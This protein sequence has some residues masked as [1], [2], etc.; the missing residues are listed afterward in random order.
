MRGHV[1]VRLA[2]DLLRMRYHLRTLMIVLALGPMVLA[3]VWPRPRGPVP[4]ATI[5]PGETAEV[6]LIQ[7]HTDTKAVIQQVLFWS[8]YPDGELHVREW[9]LLGKTKNNPRITHSLY[10]GCECSWME[11]DVECRV[12]A[13]AFQ[14]SQSPVD[15][16][17]LDR[18]KLPKPK[19]DLL[20]HWTDG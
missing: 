20:W 11:N 6:D 16:E 1:A 4:I 5:R 7:V 14:E 9:R 18:D 19:R 8:R 17:L 15:P 2:I 10:S 13:P 12:R 3:W